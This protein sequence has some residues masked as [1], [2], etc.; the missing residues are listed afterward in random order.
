M[1]E[2]GGVGGF[3][4]EPFV[5]ID[6]TG[7]LVTWNG[8][9]RRASLAGGTLPVPSVAW[10]HPW[11]ELT[12]TAL[13][14]GEP[15]RSAARATYEIRNRSPRP[16]AGTLYVA[17]RP[18]Q[19]NPPWQFLNV[20]GGYAEIGSIAWDG[21]AATVNQ[22]RALAPS[23]APAG[24]GAASFDGGSI[25][26]YLAKG[27]LPN[28]ASRRRS[29]PRRL[30]GV[31]VEPRP[32]ARRATDGLDRRPAP[33]RRAESPARGR[34]RRAMERHAGRRADRSA[35]LRRRD[36]A[37]D[38]EHA[39]IHPRESG[40]AAIQPG[41]RA[42]DRSWIRDGSLTSAALLRF[43]LTAARPPLHRVVR[44]LPVPE[45]QGALLRRARSAR[46][47]VPEN[48]SH[49]QLIFLIA[50]YVAPHRR[51]GVS[52]DRCGRTSRARSSYIDELRQQRMTAEY[53]VSG[54]ARVLRAPP[55]VDQP[56]G[57][58][59]ETD[60]LLLG[61][62]LRARGARGCGVARRRSRARRGTGPDRGDPGRATGR[63]SPRPS[64][65]RWRGTGS[66]TFPVPSSWGISMRPPRRSRSSPSTARP[67]LPEGAL[68]RTFEKYWENFVARR[69][70]RIEWDG[71]TPYE[72][73]VVG[74]FIRLG[75]AGRAH[76][77]LAWF[78]DHRR[79][80]GWNH[81]AEVVWKDPRTP[82]FIGDM[83]H[84]WVGSDFLR[85]VV[86]FL[87]VRIEGGR[88]SGDRG[89]HSGAVG[90]RGGCGQRTS[91]RTTGRCP[92]R[93]AT[94]AGRSGSLSPKGRPS[95]PAASSSRLP[96]LH[97]SSSALF[98]PRS[99]SSRAAR[100]PSDEQYRRGHAVR[101][102]FRRP[103]RIRRHRSPP[104]PPL[105]ERD[106]QSALRPRRE[107]ERAAASPGSTTP[108][109]RS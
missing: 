5:R 47:R 87:R 40:R 37:D 39:R 27:V 20:A 93:S 28:E 13:V 91:E 54:E 42:Y 46:D 55:R 1:I 11:L 61:P 43:G 70:G 29:V 108:S 81:W 4:I 92:T 10:T 7:E 49:G 80:P 100:R 9:D 83:P 66:T 71:Y 24:F 18:F 77:A 79:P 25:V 106:L 62:A 84:T 97:A 82:K 78:M 23:P 16:L 34:D 51:S 90:A 17:I 96:S 60:A 59:G 21:A 88:R 58:L 33:P 14:G 105:G 98:R 22:A 56:R 63:I 64:G 36:R 69:D 104:A 76:E 44:R 75:W 31:R 86:G 26:E 107:P 103:S 94:S 72:L 30:R 12:I 73:R 99:R 41:S 15:G 38:S 3:S 89:R 109:S 19:V 6:S 101:P 74:S 85:S 67:I 8:V 65:W 68:E 32:P 50:E 52:L 102:F 95:P 57:V 2:V 53:Q 45:R 35:S 48:D